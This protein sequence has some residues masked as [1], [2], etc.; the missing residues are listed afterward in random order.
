MPPEAPSQTR[1]P[2]EAVPLLSLLAA[3][4]D[5]ADTLLAN[6][7]LC[8][9]GGMLF[10]GP[11]GIGKSSASVQMDILWACGKAAFGIAPA[12]PLRILEIQAENDSGD[13]HEMVRGVL[14]AM[15]LS[16]ND[17]ELVT[18]N[19]HVATEQART[20]EQFLAEVVGPLLETHRP[21]LLRIDPL[22]AYLG[23]DPTDM[24]RLSRFCRNG[25]NPLLA[26]FGCACIVNH[27]TPKTTN[28]DTS[29]WRASDWMYSGAGGAELTNWAR[30]IL[31][32]E[33]TGEPH[34]FRFIAAKRGRRIGWADDDGEPV[35]ERL[36]CHSTTGIA[37]RE[38][39]HDE[40]ANVRPKGAR[41]DPAKDALLAELP[42]TG[43]LPKD[44]LLHRWNAIGLGQ[45]KARGTMA[46]LVSRGELFEWRVARPGVRPEI[47]ISRHEQTI[48]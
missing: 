46:D 5:H 40:R 17:T 29:G 28:R 21:D 2:P 12:R 20:G 32:V 42:Q 41:N 6:R 3:E 44:A 43:A 18:R 48:I 31:V 39:T 15:P 14:A 11:S 37:W 26:D 47:H 1:P 38:A 10:V 25:L 19:L 23:A 30:A 13:L 35:L 9:M 34:A 45:K 7:F 33:P 22:L 27:H 24:E 4:P 8:R 36:F 16:P